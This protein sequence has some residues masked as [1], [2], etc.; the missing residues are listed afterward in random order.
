MGLLLLVSSL[1]IWEHVI[2]TSDNQRSNEEL[3]Y[4]MLSI[5]HH[6][7]VVARDM[8]K[9]LTEDLLKVII[10]ISN[11]WK[12]P[13]KLLPPAALTHLGS[14]HGMLTGAIQVKYGNEEVLA[15]AKILLRRMH[16]EFEENVYPDWPELKQL[17]SSNEE[18]HLFAFY[19]LFFCLRN[20]TQKIDRYLKTLG[21]QIIK[22]HR[23]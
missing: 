9:I 11:A 5:S 19:K 2:S 17:R 10:N 23:C 7:R 18:R 6:T 20:D 16:L 21:S 13:L 3:Y 1:L 4:K 8:Y 15:G 12:Y 22:N 14:Y